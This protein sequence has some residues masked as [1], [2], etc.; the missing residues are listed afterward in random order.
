MGREQLETTRRGGQ[1]TGGKEGRAAP[2]IN[3]K[4]PK[5]ED[6]G[7]DSGFEAATAAMEGME[8]KPAEATWQLR[9]HLAA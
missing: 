3:F 5:G 2:L 8:E 1:T 7:D 4:I 6:S 9:G